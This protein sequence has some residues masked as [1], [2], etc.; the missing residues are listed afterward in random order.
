MELLVALMLI[1]TGIAVGVACDRQDQQT[2]REL[3][4]ENQDK[5]KQLTN[6]NDGPYRKPGGETAITASEPETRLSAWRKKRKQKK[7]TLEK[8]E[9]CAKKQ[10]IAIKQIKKEA[11]EHAEE[12]DI[13][14]LIK[15][16]IS[17]TSFER[18]NRALTCIRLR[19]IATDR[20]AIIDAILKY[21]TTSPLAIPPW[22]R[23]KSAILSLLSH[24]MYA[25]DFTD[26]ESVR[27]MLEVPIP[28]RTRSW[29]SYMDKAEIHNVL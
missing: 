20:E 12:C 28:Y 13:N 8:M 16:L 3:L 2:R 10:G 26:M 19:E 22:K 1:L 14:L 9:L 18:C 24:C 6:G 7:H 29:Q 15:M 23:R 21:S 27:I 17:E 5:P 4:S 25:R 11:R